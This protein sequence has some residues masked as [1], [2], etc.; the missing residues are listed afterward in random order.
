MLTYVYIVSISIIYQQK[1]LGITKSF[2]LRLVTL[3]I[4]FCL[5][6]EA[7]GVGEYIAYVYLCIYGFEDHAE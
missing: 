6:L 2:N 4:I 5:I 3:S 7:C 1:Q